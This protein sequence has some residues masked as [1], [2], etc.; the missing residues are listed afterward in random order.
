M[1]PEQWMKLT[2]NYYSKQQTNSSIVVGIAKALIV[3]D[4]GRETDAESSRW[5]NR[6]IIHFD[7]A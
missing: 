6:P 7:G 1:F 4:R 2:F 5:P 3:L